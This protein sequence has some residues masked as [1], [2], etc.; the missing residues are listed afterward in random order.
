[1]PKL[2]EDDL[3]EL[4]ISVERWW[5]E[6]RY[7]TNVAVIGNA[8][9]KLRIKFEN[10]LL[11]APGNDSA[12]IN[13]ALR[14]AVKV[15]GIIIFANNTTDPIRIAAKF[16]VYPKEVTIVHTKPMK[17]LALGIIDRIGK[18]NATKVHE[19]DINVTQDMAKKAI[20]EAREKIEEAE[21]LLDNVSNSSNATASE[22]GTFAGKKILLSLFLMGAK[23][24]LEKAEMAYKEGNYGKAYGLAIAAKVQAERV[25]KL[26]SIRWQDEIRV[27]PKLR[28]GL[29]LKK[30]KIW[31]KMLER[32]NITDPQLE[33]LIERLRSAIQN[34][35]Y[36]LVPSL[37]MKIRERLIQDIWSNKTK[38]REKVY[39]PVGK[40]HKGWKP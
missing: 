39:W 33:E 31:E 26:A 23:M 38:L 35:E 6:N 5:G 10:S 24:K 21:G 32:A 19:M 28:Y 17:G 40:G 34:G 16:Q 13:E 20:D 2:Y 18:G 1:V 29:I 3:R 8:T 25:I 9:V 30:A 4:N 12:A 37:M 15:H 22:N 27:D 36:D 7:E 14:K 11:V